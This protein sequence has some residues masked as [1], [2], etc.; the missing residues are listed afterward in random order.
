MTGRPVDSRYPKWEMQPSHAYGYIATT[1]AILA[2]GGRSLLSSR[3]GPARSF[4]PSE[5]GFPLLRPC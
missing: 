1:P 4:R 3:D 2:I 5:R